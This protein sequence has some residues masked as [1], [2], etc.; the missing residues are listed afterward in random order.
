MSWRT[1]QSQVGIKWRRESNAL[2]AP[3]N[4]RK[5]LNR[6]SQL[7]SIG[8]CFAMNINRWLAFQGFSVPPVTWGM[9]YNCRAILY[10]LQRAV[11]IATPTMD[12]IVN[13]NDGSTA[14]V[15]AL[16]HSIDASSASELERLKA[17]I[18]Q[19][20]RD[21]FRAADCFL[22]TLGLSDVWEV[23]V[24]GQ[25]VTLNRSPYRN[26]WSIAGVSPEVTRNRFLSVDEC[27]RDIEQIVALIRAHK[28]PGTPIV[29][30]VSPVPLKHTSSKYHPHVAN[31]R[32]KS[33]L[34]S[35]IYSFLDAEGEA[36]EVS[37]FPSFEFFL[38]NPKNLRIWQDDDRHPTAEAVAAVAE[39]FVA[40][41]SDLE[42]EP[43]EGFVVP[44]FH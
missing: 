30:T 44:E 17:V 27:L 39:G 31:L 14:Y 5:F 16:R 43:K 11:G 21:S 12:W 29:I 22:I 2:E 10:E 35:A 24:E 1:T 34:L 8:S 42:I 13:R 4:P 28:S 18:S 15:D 7:Y 40:I 25:T 33:I 20:S 9:H 6:S 3:I 41:Y 36:S 37:Y 38:T 32:S 23:D 26:A 19:E